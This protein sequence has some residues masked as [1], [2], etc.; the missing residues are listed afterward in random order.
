MSV[1]D[2][3]FLMP[4]TINISAEVTHHHC[5]GG[6]YPV[7]QIQ[8]N[9]LEDGDISVVWCEQNGYQCQKH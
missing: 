6:N 1:N 3:F 8:N 5:H 9:D 7:E 2:C 4:F